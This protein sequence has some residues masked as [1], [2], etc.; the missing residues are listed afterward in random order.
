MCVCDW[1]IP[2]SIMPSEFIYIVAC[3]RIS[4]LLRLNNA[5]LNI[6]TTFCYPV[7]FSWTFAMF[8]FLV[9]V[10]N[11]AMNAGVQVSVYIPLFNFGGYAPMSGISRSLG[12]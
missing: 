2:C 5:V 11:A 10:N 8:P 6:Y 7:F 3:L 9:I 12:N 1:L 4:F